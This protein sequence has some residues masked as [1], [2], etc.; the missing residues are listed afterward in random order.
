MFDWGVHNIYI[1]YHSSKQSNFNIVIDFVITMSPKLLSRL[2]TIYKLTYKKIFYS[3]LDPFG[4]HK[5]HNNQW[6]MFRYGPTNIQ[7]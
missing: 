5:Q 7:N 3:Q 2:Y 6:S 4:D 1:G